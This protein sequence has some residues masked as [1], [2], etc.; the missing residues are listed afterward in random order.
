MTVRGPKLTRLE[1]NL[2]IQYSDQSTHM[3][4]SSY[5]NG[6]EHKSSFCSVVPMIVQSQLSKHRPTPRDEQSVQDWMEAQEKLRM[7]K[8]RHSFLP[9][10]R[11]LPLNTPHGATSLV[12]PRNKAA[13]VTNERCSESPSMSEKLRLW[14]ESW[15]SLTSAFLP[16]SKLLW[17]SCSSLSSRTCHA[18]FYWLHCGAS[19][20]GG[21]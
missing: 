3:A 12:K 18:A 2:I 15:T 20:R 11:F 14:S 10:P 4:I 21:S 9:N 1:F 17:G 6:N 8:D 5:K 7:L 19:L 13:N 16:L